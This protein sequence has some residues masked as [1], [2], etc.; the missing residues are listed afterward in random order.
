MNR[1]NSCNL[2]RTKCSGDQP[3]S[4]CASSSRECVYPAPAVK[5]TISREEIDSLRRK[6]KAYEKALQ[7]AVPDPDRRQELITLQTSFGSPSEPSSTPQH[8]LQALSPVRTETTSTTDEEP[9]LPGIEGR[10]LHD[11]IGT[12]RFHGETSEIALIDSLKSHLYGQLTPGELSSVRHT[13][14]RCHTSDSKPL[15][16]SDADVF[17]LPPAPTSR[18]MLALLRSFI[19]D[20]SDDSPYPSGGIYWWGG[21]SSTPSVPVSSGHVETDI[22]SARR[23]AFYQT[24]LG[25]ACRI[26]STRPPSPGHPAAAVSDRSDVYFARAAVLLGN[27][28]DVSR[29]S[30]GEVSVLTLMAYYLLETDRREAACLYVSLA[31]RISM[32]LGVHRGHVDE[33]GRRIFWTLYVLDRWLSCLMG[34]PPSIP[35]EAIRL[36]LPADAP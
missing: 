23:L 3:C 11:A 9:P 30:V 6:V 2:R 21:L 22:R 16:S 20:G 4:Q 10:L 15:P 7:D 33:R 34:R 14:G 5:I 25:V 13:V 19:Q 1:C 17:W 12:A 29:C 26:A 32:A 35:D 31:T 27:P 36:P 8:P 28:L 24:A 18:A